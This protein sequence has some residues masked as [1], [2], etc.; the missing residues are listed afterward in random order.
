MHKMRFDVLKFYG[1]DDRESTRWINRIEH[2]FELQKM[3]DD[4]EKINFASL[5]LYKV[6][7]D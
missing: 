5:H 1:E 3:C 6:A 7:S 2:Y 4:K